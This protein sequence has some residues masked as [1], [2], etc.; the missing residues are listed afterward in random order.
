[1]TLLLEP[2]YQKKVQASPDNAGEMLHN[3]QRLVWLDGHLLQAA[4]LKALSGASQ[5]AKALQVLRADVEGVMLHRGSMATTGNV[6]LHKL[7]H[8]QR[9]SP[10]RGQ[11]V[12]FW[13]AA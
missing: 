3:H 1:M 2:L 10:W 7:A 5:V 11:A 12:G 9:A 13:E 4:E 6:R 8:L